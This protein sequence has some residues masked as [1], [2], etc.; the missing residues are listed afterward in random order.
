MENT[1]WLAWASR[2]DPSFEE[3]KDEKLYG[4]ATS[5]AARFGDVVRRVGLD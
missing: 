4:S 5:D 3:V 2:F 1:D